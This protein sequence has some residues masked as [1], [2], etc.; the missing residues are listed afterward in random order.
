MPSPLPYFLDDFPS[1]GGALKQR[2]EDFFVTEI[3]AYEPS[4]EGEHVMAE[5][6]KIGMTTPDAVRLLARQLGVERRVV[7]YAGMKDARAVTRQIMTISGVT[8]EQVREVKTDGLAVLWAARHRNKIRLGHLAG[9]RF[10]VRVREVDP[11]RVIALLPALAVLERRGVANYFGQQRFG[12]RDENDLLGAAF[13]R[14]DDA[15]VLRLLLG[16]P[17]PGVD[18]PRSLEAR[19]AFVAGD[20]ERSMSALP[21]WAHSERA[22]LSRFIRTADAAAAVRA[23]DS[24]VRRLWVSAFQSRIFN[25]VLAARVKNIDRLIDGDIAF[26]HENGACFAVPLAAA[27]QPRADAFEISA[28]GPMIGAT[29]LRPDGRAL[30]IETAALAAA[31]VSAEVF[32]ANDRDQAPGERRPLRVRPT[33]LRAESGVDAHGPYIT[34]GFT[35]PRGA[36]AT[37]LLRELMRNDDA[38]AQAEAP[39]DSA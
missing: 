8:P 3:P 18:A 22:A 14:G 20:H 24:T 4:G 34:L 10:V 23:V 16:D 37:V 21:R 6:Q 5:V 32:T 2:A 35:L 15:A 26:K 25:D 27:E 33:E 19:E 38:V 1:I 12:V 7:G 31:G 39:G 13:L 17:R 29:M 36:Y 9:N 30:E 28:T 11:M